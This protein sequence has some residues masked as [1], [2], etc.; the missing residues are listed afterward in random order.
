MVV[1]IL[2]TSFAYN[3]NCSLEFY[4]RDLWINNYSLFT[5]HVST[6][7]WPNSFWTPCRLHTQLNSNW[8]SCVALT[9]DWLNSNWITEP[10]LPVLS[11]LLCPTI[12][13]LMNALEGECFCLR[14]ISINV[15]RLLILLLLHV[16]I[17]VF[18]RHFFIGCLFFKTLLIFLY[19]T[20]LLLV[21]FWIPLFY[22]V[23]AC[24]LLYPLHYTEIVAIFL[25]TR[26][27][28]KQA[29]YFCFWSTCLV[30]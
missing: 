6:Q 30:F 29:H 26:W 4:S 23:V 21:Y 9:Y 12:S 1:I 27:L 22:N 15:N 7:D 24:L 11:C 3:N 25:F 5:Q 19:C 10:P 20:L 28:C 17:L 14:E 8:T 13:R 2:Y 16:F 18:I